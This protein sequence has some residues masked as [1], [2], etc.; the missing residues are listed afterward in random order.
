[1]EE[2]ASQVG[3]TTLQIDE[4]AA[5]GFNGQGLPV[6]ALFGKS[7]IVDEIF[8]TTLDDEAFMKDDENGGYYMVKLEEI[9][10]SAIRAY[11]TVAAPVQADWERAEKNKGALSEAKAFQ[12]AVDAGNS[13][14]DVVTGF[15]SR[16][17][18]C[19][20]RGQP[21]WGG[22]CRGSRGHPRYDRWQ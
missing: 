15:R 22:C 12:E 13:F 17:G 4:V 14:T 5:N 8:A 18:D 10:P 2:A 21:R 20:S 11:D 6:G 3:L 9:T 1:M 19:C 16:A 7:F